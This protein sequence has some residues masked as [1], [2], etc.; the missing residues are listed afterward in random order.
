MV[1]GQWAVCGQRLLQGTNL[2]AQFNIGRDQLHI[3]VLFAENSRV[4][5]TWRH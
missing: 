1:A 5:A 3:S 4:S 2:H